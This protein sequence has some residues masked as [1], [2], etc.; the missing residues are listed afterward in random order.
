[1]T[2]QVTWRLPTD[3]WRLLKRLR[4][5]LRLTLL[6]ASRS[7]WLHANDNGPHDSDKAALAAKAALQQL[8]NQWL[9]CDSTPPTVGSALS[10]IFLY[11][12]LVPRH[13]LRQGPA[14]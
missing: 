9:C 2:W 11:V 13:S 1:L 10:R 12:K 5:R 6:G 3:Y 14:V 4:Y 7:D 8:R